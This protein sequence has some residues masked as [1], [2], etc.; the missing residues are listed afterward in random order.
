MW[1]L[2]S[3]ELVFFMACVRVLR[4][5]NVCILTVRS[6]VTTVEMCIAMLCQMSKH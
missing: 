2:A 5:D 4:G 1:G 6:C 3:T